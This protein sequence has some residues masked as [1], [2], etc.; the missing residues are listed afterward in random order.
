MSNRPNP[1][2]RRAPQATTRGAGAPPAR[3]PWWL[4]VVGVLVV[5]FAVAV[6]LSVGGD[7]EETGLE[8][9]GGTIPTG[10]TAVPASDQEHGE[11]VVSGATLPELSS[12]QDAAVGQPA[13]AVSGTGFDGESVELPANGR[14]TLVFFLAHWCPH[15]RAEV[16][17]VAEWLL[18][19]GMPDGVDLVAVATANDRTA[20]N[21]PAGEWLHRE[22]WAVP[23]MLDDEAGSAA[24]A[25]GVSGFPF[26]VAVDGE[27][28]VVA[29]ASGEIGVD[30]VEELLAAVSGPA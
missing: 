13:P 11:V 16:P 18:E 6:A 21:F 4:L 26:F 25:F 19:E 9:P 30:G 5:G 27:G 1:R 20:V 23:T 14:P 29:R 10:E 22:G 3:R 2:A 17:R 28:R 12:G 8:L 24:E 7:G 15:C